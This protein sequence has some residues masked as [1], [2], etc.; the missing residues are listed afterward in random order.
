MATT[1][2]LLYLI[3]THPFYLIQQHPSPTAMQSTA[4]AP[5]APLRIAS[6]T[7]TSF[8]CDESP[9]APAPTAVP[10]PSAARI[11]AS[12]GADDKGD[13]K[14]LF[15]RLKESILRPIVTVPGGGQG[16]D[17]LECTFCKGAGRNDCDACRG[18]GK[19]A[20]GTCMM[21]DGKTSLTCTVCEGVGT[22]DRIRR[23]GTDDSNEYTVRKKR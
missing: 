7:R 1:K 22:V 3:Y 19:D 13:K 21:C 2:P 10:H 4:F 11:T 9:V 6:A 5:P 16:G 15:S 17:L 12:A 20:L 23:G 8:L 18:S 14:G